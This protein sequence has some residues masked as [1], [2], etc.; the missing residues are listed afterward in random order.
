M[1]LA[2]SLE[3]QDRVKQIF[4]GAVARGYAMGEDV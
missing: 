2:Y 4:Q 3:L 1:D